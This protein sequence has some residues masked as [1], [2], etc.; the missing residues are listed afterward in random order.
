VGVRRPRRT[1][2]GVELGGVSQGPSFPAHHLGSM[3]AMNVLTP[4]S[5]L[6]TRASVWSRERFFLGL[7]G[8]E[9]RATFWDVFELR[10]CSAGLDQS[11]FCLWFSFL[12]VPYPSLSVAPLCP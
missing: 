12:P 7:Q 4:G 9:V 11:F 5:V 6:A 10:G 3:V 1:G 2:N 8:P